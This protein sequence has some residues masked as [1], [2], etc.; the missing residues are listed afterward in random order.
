MKKVLIWGTGNTSISM[1]SC[2][3]KNVNIIA[4]IDSNPKSERFYDVNVYLPEEISRFDFDYL[5]ICSVFMDDILERAKQLNID[6]AKI[7]L[8]NHEIY[9]KYL[10]YHHFFFHERMNNFKCLKDSVQLLITGIS[11]LNDGI[12][13]KNLKV[14]SYNFSYRSQDLFCDYEI[15]KYLFQNHQLDSVKHVIIGLNYYSFEYDLSKSIGSWQLMR[16]YPYIKNL[17]NL[18]SPKYY[19]EYFNYSI[20][21]LSALKLPKGLFVYNLRK[22][23]LNDY[24]GERTAKADFNKNYPAT[25]FENKKILSDF[26]DFLE[27]KLIV[28]IFVIVPCTKF[29]TKYCT[30]KTKKKFYDNLNE[31]IKDKNIQIL[32]YFDS[33]DYPDSYYY[34]VSHLNKQG[35]KVFTEQLNSDIRW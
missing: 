28:P 9:E 10:V 24:E 16:Y 15:M 11:Y 33:L 13:A 6:S 21:N 22:F 20:Q 23:D 31:V 17:H 4:F 18:V 26:I 29:Y 3:S 7:I 12:Y 32:D 27:D 34:H 2:I 25:V 35:A 8:W 30:S 19:D 1:M 5:I 14:P